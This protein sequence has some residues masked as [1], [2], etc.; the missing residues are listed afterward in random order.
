MEKGQGATGGR[1]SAL[2]ADAET[3]IRRITPILDPRRHKGQAGK[4]S[5]YHTSNFFNH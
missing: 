5:M 3:V 4:V 1:T 2:E